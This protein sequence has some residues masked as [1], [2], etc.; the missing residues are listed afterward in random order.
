[1]VAVRVWWRD[2]GEDAR[3]NES[4]GA[5]VMRVSE[6][7]LV[8]RMVSGNVVEMVVAGVRRSEAARCRR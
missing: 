5:V 7:L 2:G 8:A 4:E 1:M 3:W 6:G